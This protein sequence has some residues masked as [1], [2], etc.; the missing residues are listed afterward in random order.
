MPQ[1]NLNVIDFHG[2][3]IICKVP[4]CKK[5]LYSTRGYIQHMQKHEAN[6]EQTSGFRYTDNDRPGKVRVRTDLMSPKSVRKYRQECEACLRGEI[7]ELDGSDK[8]SNPRGNSIGATS[9][10]AADMELGVPNGNDND[11]NDDGDNDSMD[12]TE[13]VNSNGGGKGVDQNKK[14]A[15]A[16]GVNFSPKDIVKILDQY[17]EYCKKLGRENK[18]GFLRDVIWNP[19]GE[20]RRVKFQ[21]RQL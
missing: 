8:D 10:T 17:H 11:T 9:S 7:I 3:A 19:D 16:Q 12:E 2:G 20:W 4:G 1:Q 18:K 5:H 21:N 14:A 6:G 13:G 15:Q